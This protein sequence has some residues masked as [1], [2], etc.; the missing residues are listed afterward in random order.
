MTPLNDDE[1]R[2][3]VLAGAFA[4]LRNGPTTGEPPPLE[5]KSMEDALKA[6]QKAKPRTTCIAVEGPYEITESWNGGKCYLLI[7]TPWPNAVL[8]VGKDGETED[9]DDIRDERVSLKEQL[10]ELQYEYD[11]L[12]ADH[13][14]GEP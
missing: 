9:I 4:I 2:C 5:V 13:Q 8:V 3:K 10:K 12:L 6:V 7:K 1:A 14:L 11:V